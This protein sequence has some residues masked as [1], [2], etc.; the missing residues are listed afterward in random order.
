M[1]DL[2]KVKKKL[3][4]T[5]LGQ[6]DWEHAVYEDE[7]GKVF[8]NI[9]EYGERELCTVS[10]GFDG[11]PDTPLRSIE[12]YRD[13]E[14]IIIGEP[15]RPTR[16]ETFNYQMLSRLKQD[17][18]YYLGY[19]NRNKKHLWAGSVEEQIKEMKK[20]HNSF[21]DNKKPEWLTMGEILEYESKMMEK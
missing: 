1:A 3:V 2:E 10:G 17:C 14:I 12:R 18:D 9:D 19:G 7:N 11:E 20:I 6:D 16:E 4:L 21:E 5:Y 13:V 15:E 8:K